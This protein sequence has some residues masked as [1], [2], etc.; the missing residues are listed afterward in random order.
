[1]TVRTS[2]EQV[3]EF[4]KV[5]VTLQSGALSFEVSKLAIWEQFF[6]LHRVPGLPHALPAIA[7]TQTI[8]RHRHTFRGAQYNPQWRTPA[9]DP[10][11]HK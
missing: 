9:L 11:G 4:Q 5:C 8:S 3:P 10:A 6:V 2:P 1:M 7:T